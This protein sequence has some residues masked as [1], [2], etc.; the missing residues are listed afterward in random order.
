MERSSRKERSEGE[1]EIDIIKRIKQRKQQK[2]YEM[3]SIGV[4]GK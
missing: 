2:G 3:E 1:R 4:R